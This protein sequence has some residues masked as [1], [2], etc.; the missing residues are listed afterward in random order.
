MALRFIDGFDHYSTADITAKW[1][2]NNGGT[3]SAGGRSGNRLNHPQTVSS[4]SITLDSQ[5]TWYAGFVWFHGGST[6]QRMM[7]FFDG[8]TNHIDFRP[9][10]GNFLA[11]LRNGT[12][13][14]TG[15]IPLTAGVF[16]HIQ[17]RVTIADAGGRVVTKING[18]TDIDFTGDTRNGANASA[19]VITLGGINSS[20]TTQGWDDMWICDATGS[21]NNDF[22]GDVKV[23]TIFPTGA[24]NYAQFIPSAGSNYQNVD[25]STPNSDT[26]YNASN[27]LNDIDTFTMGDLVTTAGEIM[28]V[29]HNLHAKKIDAGSRS[30]K[31]IARIASSDYLAANDHSL[32]NSYAVHRQIVELNP[33]T[34]LDWTIADINTNAEFGYKLTV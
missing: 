10:A 2:S 33:A 12:N 29:Q 31:P 17:V 13:I 19:N 28:G 9:A 27:T 24:G 25:E 4:T 34:G 22:L 14:A 16:Y 8:A 23:E 3:I 30:I 7:G 6:S 20:N 11:A 5:A 21:N 1:T 18:V 15:T 32:G 26:D